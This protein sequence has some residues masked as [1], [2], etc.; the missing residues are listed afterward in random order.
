M[1]RRKLAIAAALA[2]TVRLGGGAAAQTVIQLDGALSLGYTTTSNQTVARD[3]TEPPPDVNQRLYTDI[4]PSAAVQ[5]DTA[6]A[7]YGAGYTF[8]GSV[9]LDGSGSSTYSNEVHGSVAAL[10]S[11]RSTLTFLLGA[12]QGGTAFQLSQRPAD[13]SSPEIRAPGD[14]N[15]VA[16]TFAE[17]LSFA[18]S[19]FLRVGQGITAGLNAPQDD[20]GQ[21][22][23]N[24]TAYLAVDRVFARDALGAD[25]QSSVARL[26]P[27]S[28]QGDPYLNITNSL[29]ARWSHDLSLRWGARFTG[30][31]QQVVT[32]TG[33]YPL[34]I[35]PTASA[36]A[37]YVSGSAAGSL[38]ASYGATTNLQTGTVSTTQQVGAH[39]LL[40]FDPLH[41]RLLGVSA[42]FL[43]NE[44]LGAAAIT[45]AAGTGNAVQADVG[46]VWG[47]SPTVLATAR[48][49]LA[50]QFGQDAGVEPSLAQVFLVGIT[51]RYT[52]GR[53]HPPLPL[54]GQR[55]EGNDA[56]RAPGSELRRP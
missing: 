20:L 47:L 12:T 24:A 55:V 5:V 35:L 40:S 52:T 33:S 6:R 26:Q 18:A 54:L 7:S 38:A 13:A 32:L 45:V 1:A 51:A 31:V 21:L 2:V 53:Y 4:R 14:P 36:T 11:S 25:V 39:A 9:N 49:S 8:A 34:A 43:H 17:T 15:R 44:P 23:A 56:D 37:T 50:Y 30:G 41:P 48:Y 42:G 29:L 10:L 27:A 3:P 19:G 46:L 22:N 28:T 16:A